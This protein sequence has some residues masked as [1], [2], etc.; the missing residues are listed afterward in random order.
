MGVRADA[1]LDDDDPAHDIKLV[2]LVAARKVACTG[3]E[4]CK[5]RAAGAAGD[6]AAEAVAAMHAHA[7]ALG[8]HVV[9][10]YPRL[11]GLVADLLARAAGADGGNGGGGVWDWEA[12]GIT[13]GANGV[14]SLSPPGGQS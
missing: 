5:G 4:L 2:A 9:P 11:R 12:E 8:A 3:E 10:D 7:R 6:A 1:G 14:L 13:W